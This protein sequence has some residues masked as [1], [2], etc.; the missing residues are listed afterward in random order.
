MHFSIVAAATILASVASAS[1]HGSMGTTPNILHTR[2]VLLGRQFSEDSCTSS[3][4]QKHVSES[5]PA[6]DKAAEMAEDADLDELAKELTKCGCSVVKEQD[7]DFGN[8]IE[9][10]GGTTWDDLK[11]ACKSVD[12][13]SEDSKDSDD[14]EEDAASLHSASYLLM[15]GGA[16][17][18][19]ML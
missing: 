8:C 18:A 7:D 1:P 11:E 5:T 13:D 19:L 3:C 6:C 16:F 15:A 12:T 17:A 9:E 4:V 2:S 14:S 10:C